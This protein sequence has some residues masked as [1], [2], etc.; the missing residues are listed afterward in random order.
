MATTPPLSSSEA[1]LSPVNAFFD[2]RGKVWVADVAEGQV[3]LLETK[4][5]R[6]RVVGSRGSGPGEFRAPIGIGQI[7]DSV[8]VYDNRLRR[9]SFFREERYAA[10]MLVPVN[11]GG[12]EG[13]PEFL[14]MG[15][16]GAGISVIR[17]TARSPFGARGTVRHSI[18]QHTLDVQD[19]RSAPRILSVIQSLSGDI[20]V[21][22][23]W[24]GTAGEVR[25]QNPLLFAPHIVGDA[26]GGVVVVSSSGE[27]AASKGR[28]RVAS[29][30]SDGSQSVHHVELDARPIS[31]AILDDILDN[32]CTVEGSAADQPVC[33]RS[34]LVRGLGKHE[35]LPL[36]TGVVACQHA[37]GIWLRRADWPLDATTEYRF[38]SASRR[39]VQDF[40][41]APGTRV[42]GCNSDTVALV[43][44]EGRSAVSP[45]V[46]ARIL[47]SR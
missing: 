44:M 9:L 19:S 7:G 12:V 5:S 32:F 30:R 16:G 22:T 47:S 35:Y 31:R 41:F 27:I 38:V 36:V 4:S 11:V 1:L 14:T 45:V 15:E 8:W 10:S 39:T 13:T 43:Q 26:S 2:S 34:D 24:R 37:S 6:W 42:I 18:V 46:V 33:N 17:S 20:V 3:G 25:A 21:R 28:V 29:L 40:R 23:R